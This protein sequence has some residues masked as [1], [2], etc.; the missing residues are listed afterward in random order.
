ML[1]LKEIKNIFTYLYVGDSKHPR[2]RA[3][4]RNKLIDGVLTQSNSMKIVGVLKRGEYNEKYGEA[5]LHNCI[6]ELFP[7]YKLLNSLN[8]NPIAQ[9]YDDVSEEFLKKMLTE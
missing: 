4:P 5:Y 7:Q 9:G 3:N 2:T 8:P 1:Y 6:K